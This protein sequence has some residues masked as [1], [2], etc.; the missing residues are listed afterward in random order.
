MT[1]PSD[2]SSA[3]STMWLRNLDP[4]APA[5][6]SAYSRSKVRSKTNVNATKSRKIS[7]ETAAKITVSSLVSGC[8]KVR[9]N[10]AC[11]K[12]MAN[13]KNRQM[14]SATIAGVRLG[15]CFGRIGGVD[16]N[17][18][19]RYYYSPIAPLPLIT[20]RKTSDQPLLYPRLAPARARPEQAPNFAPA[21]NP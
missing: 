21:L 3:P 11:A 6:R 7:A 5:L 2:N 1:G 13:R 18:A 19:K 17:I 16:G 14:Q 20:L 15:F 8:R 4:R 9:L 10:V 12:M